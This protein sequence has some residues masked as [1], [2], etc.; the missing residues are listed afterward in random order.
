MFKNISANMTHHFK[1]DD[2]EFIDQ[3]IEDLKQ[4]VAKVGRILAVAVPTTIIL[5]VT[6]HVV[7]EIAIS[8]LTNK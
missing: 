1:E 7:G 2:K 3:K 4:S 5:A 8:K 6:A